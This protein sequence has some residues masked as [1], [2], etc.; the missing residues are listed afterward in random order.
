MDRTEQRM[1]L[2]YQNQINKNI[3]KRN[4]LCKHEDPERCLN[5][6][7]KHEMHWNVVPHHHCKFQCTF[8]QWNTLVGLG[9][10]AFTLP[11]H[12]CKK[13]LKLQGKDIWIVISIIFLISNM[14]PHTREFGLWAWTLHRSTEPFNEIPLFYLKK[15]NSKDQTLNQW[16]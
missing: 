16:S 1:L 2:I 9:K 4:I 5:I 11:Q 13:A 12:K 14:P 3:K 6:L 7:C 15:G 10:C 8:T